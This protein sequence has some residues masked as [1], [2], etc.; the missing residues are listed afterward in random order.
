MPIQT[1]RREFELLDGPR[2]L[3]MMY[4]TADLAPLELATAKVRSLRLARRAVEICANVH[5]KALGHKSAAAMLTADPGRMLHTRLKDWF[6]LQVRRRQGMVW[7]SDTANFVFDCFKNDWRLDRGSTT[8]TAFVRVF[9]G[10]AEALHEQCCRPAKDVETAWKP[11]VEAL[12]NTLQAVVAGLSLGDIYLYVRKM[13]AVGS[14]STSYGDWRYVGDRLEQLRLESQL[15]A[16]SGSPPININIE[17]LRNE[18]ETPELSTSFGDY[19][20]LY[21][22]NLTLEDHITKTLIHEASHKFAATADYYYYRPRT[23][24]L[25]C[26]R[27]GDSPTS[28]GDLPTAETDRCVVNAD[29]IGWFLYFWGDGT[30][31]ANLDKAK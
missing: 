14:A 21:G 28:V 4:D 8:K 9:G 12:L 11:R 10:D 6:K 22:E 17:Y 15:S 27:G 26:E 24:A 2:K 29:S 31:T 23:G 3:H 18:V 25:R 7:T 16:V 5:A 20:N 30:S 1:F 13:A 19:R